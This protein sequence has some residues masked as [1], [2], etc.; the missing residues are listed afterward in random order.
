M[1][2]EQGGKHLK[3]NGTYP[4]RQNNTFIRNNVLSVELYYPRNS[5]VKIVEIGLTDVRAA[6]SI[7]VKYDFE[8][9]GWVI[10]Q[11]SIFEWEGDDDELEADW[12]EVAFVEAW[13][14]SGVKLASY[15]RHR[16]S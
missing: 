13:G 3:I 14:R 4:G 10:E 8:R 7:R 12:Q 1:K 9:D 5:P 16:D 6:D 2:G 11:A 15:H